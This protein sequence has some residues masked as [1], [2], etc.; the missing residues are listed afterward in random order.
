MPA[1]V[2]VAHCKKGVYAMTLLAAGAVSYAPVSVSAAES[3]EI[4]AAVAARQIRILGFNLVAAGEV[5]MTLEDSD[6][7]NL[8]GPVTLIKGV[9]FPATPCD[10][11]HQETAA[12]KALHLLLGG[13]VQVGGCLVYQLVR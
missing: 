3:N 9:P 1:Y 11:G 6:G 10:T 8:V 5:V 13:A 2:R 7:A 12:G 4:V